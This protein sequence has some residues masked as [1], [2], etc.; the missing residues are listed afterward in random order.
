MKKITANLSNLPLITID[1]LG[2]G[3]GTPS[4]LG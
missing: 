2:G 3:G 1:L 4:D